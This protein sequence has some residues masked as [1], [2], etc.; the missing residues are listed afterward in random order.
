VGGVLSGWLRGLLHVTCYL[1]PIL[2]MFVHV[3]PSLLLRDCFPLRPPPP[4]LDG[5]HVNG[6]DGN[7]SGTNGD[8]SG[9]DVAQSQSYSLS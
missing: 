6:N 7:N 3:V 5:S 8:G 9:S 4:Q 1:A 2:S